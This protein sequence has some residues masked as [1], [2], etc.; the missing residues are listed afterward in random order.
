MTLDDGTVL[1]PFSS[2]IDGVTGIILDQD[3]R[4]Y[5]GICT[6]VNPTPRV[7]PVTDSLLTGVTIEFNTHNDDKN[8][9]TTL[10][11]HI[12]NQLSATE[13]QDI[14]VAP[15]TSDHGQGF[16]DSGDTYKRIDLP[17]ASNAI[18]LR[19]MVLPIVFYQHRRRQRQVDLRLPRHALLRRG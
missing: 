15:W 5:Y 2:D 16:P 19:D 8:A 17:L 11:I 10:N 12:V 6:E 4:N 14:S 3:N 9:D 13:S 18:F 7:A 1:P